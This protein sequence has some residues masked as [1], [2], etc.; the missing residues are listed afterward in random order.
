MRTESPAHGKTHMTTSTTTHVEACTRMRSKQDNAQAS[1]CN[2]KRALVMGPNP[3]S[4]H[5][6]A[7]L[8]LLYPLS[9]R[10]AMSRNVGVPSHTA[11]GIPP[12]LGVCLP[13]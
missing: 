9:V 8:G 5:P 13:L 3:Y 4:T 10:V 6:L 7:K 2:T 12:S 1:F 11:G